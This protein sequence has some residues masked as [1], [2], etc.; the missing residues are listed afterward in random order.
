M[1]YRVRSEGMCKA[2]QVIQTE[3]DGS[4]APRG[5]EVRPFKGHQGVVRGV[6]GGVF[7]RGHQHRV[8]LFHQQSRVQ[9]LVDLL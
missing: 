1:T 4:A 8:I 7:V 6:L 9:V 5:L 2:C 3:L